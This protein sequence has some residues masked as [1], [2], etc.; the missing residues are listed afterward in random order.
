MRT[1]GKV[2]LNQRAVVKVI[3]QWPG[4][5]VVSSANLGAGFSDLILGYRGR[6]ILLEVKGPKGKLTPQQIAFHA[7]WTGSPVVILRSEDDAIALM[8]KLDADYRHME[9]L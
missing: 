3:R 7:A 2:D 5:T 8:Q 4:A 1:H 6:T 9:K